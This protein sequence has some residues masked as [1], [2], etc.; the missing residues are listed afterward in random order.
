MIEIKSKTH[1]IELLNALEEQGYITSD[2][3]VEDLP[4]KDSSKATKFWKLK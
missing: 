3:M 4:N 2:L 1:A